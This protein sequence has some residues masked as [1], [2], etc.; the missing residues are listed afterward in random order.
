MKGLWEIL[1]IEPDIKDSESAKA[2][3]DIAGDVE[4]DNVCFGYNDGTDVLK[5]VSFKTSAGCIYCTG[6]TIRSR[7]EYIM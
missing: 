7:K 3:D 4:F 2:Y 1:N 6:R 5:N